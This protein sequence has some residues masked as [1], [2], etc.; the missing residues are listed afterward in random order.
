MLNRMNVP[1]SRVAL[2]LLAFI[3]GLGSVFIVQY[4]VT[5]LWDSFGISWGPNNLPTEPVQQAAVLLTTFVAGVAGP[6]VATFIVRRVPWVVLA[7]MCS[8]GLA[9]DGY[10]AAY[11]LSALPSWFRIAFV[12]SVPFQILVGGYAGY[13]LLN[14]GRKSGSAT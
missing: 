12:V 2:S 9:I 14:L 13:R 4:G 5:H 3:G 11:P 8:V 7:A 10:A 6:I 1:W